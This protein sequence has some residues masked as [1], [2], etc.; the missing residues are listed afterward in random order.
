MRIHNVW[1]LHHHFLQPVLSILAGSRWLSVM[2]IPLS[3]ARW[4]IERGI[5]GLR[6]PQSH[7]QFTFIGGG[8]CTYDHPHPSLRADFL[9]SRPT[10]LPP[11]RF[12]PRFPLP[13]RPETSKVS[14]DF[15]LPKSLYKCMRYHFTNP[16]PD[17]MN[18]PTIDVYR[19]L[20]DKSVLDNVI[21]SKA[22]RRPVYASTTQAAVT[23]VWRIGAHGSL[24]QIAMIDWEQGSLSF[25]SVQRKLDDVLVKSKSLF[26]REWVSLSSRRPNR[27]GLPVI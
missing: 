21:H 22:L 3:G 13:A 18:P 25:G 15:I 17:R 4:S 12:F 20:P 2:S 23:R 9:S 1:V 7:S 27:E 24:T 6:N 26:Q 14:A 8:E 19:L 11:P 16:H 10:T 5:S